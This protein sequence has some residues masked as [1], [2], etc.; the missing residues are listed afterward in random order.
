MTRIRDI[1]NEPDAQAEARRRWAK[2]NSAGKGF[3][4]TDELLEDAELILY[5]LTNDEMHVYLLPD[6]REIAVTAWGRW[7]VDVTNP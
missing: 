6:G 1:S 3:A 7:A 2:G 5:A 4:L